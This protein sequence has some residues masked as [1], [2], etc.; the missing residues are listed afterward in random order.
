MGT[1]IMM[2][3]IAERGEEIKKDLKERRRHREKEGGREDKR[4]AMRLLPNTGSK[5]NHECIKSIEILSHLSHSV[6]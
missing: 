3:M 2:M 4:K 1:M 6:L 5:N